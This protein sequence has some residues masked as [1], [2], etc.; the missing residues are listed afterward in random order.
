MTTTA[1]FDRGGALPPNLRTPK[2]ASSIVGMLIFVGT[3]LMFF[4]ALVSAYLVIRQ[5]S[6]NFVPPA[7]VR[8]PVI[9]TGINTAFLLTSGI[10]LYAAG[11]FWQY[12]YSKALWLYLAACILGLTFVTVQGMEWIALIRLGMTMKS[13]VFGATFFLVI[14][15]HGVHAALAVA[16]MLWHLRKAWRGKLRHES[17]QALQIFWYF[18]V[19]IWPLLYALVYF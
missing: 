3:E 6:G 11:R 15:S 14:G 13:G 5:S 7:D 19:G 17:F 4:L 9:V 16:A 18:I 1:F 2:V 10:C 8:L 12:A